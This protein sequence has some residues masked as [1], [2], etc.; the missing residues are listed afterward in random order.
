MKGQEI[1]AVG[2]GNKAKLDVA[3]NKE[4]QAATSSARTPIKSQTICHPTLV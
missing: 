3:A 1:E 2:E 4:R